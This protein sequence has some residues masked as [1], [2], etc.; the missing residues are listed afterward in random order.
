MWKMAKDEDWKRILKEMI[1]AYYSK[2]WN[3]PYRNQG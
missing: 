3:I 1:L 2:L